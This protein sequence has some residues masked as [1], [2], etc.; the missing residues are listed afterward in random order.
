[1][2]SVYSGIAR[3][4]LDFGHSLSSR[5]LSRCVVR[6]I[7]NSVR[8]NIANC[9]AIFSRL[10]Q[11]SARSSASNFAHGLNLASHIQNRLHHGHARRSAVKTVGLRQSGQRS[12]RD[13]GLCCA[14]AY[15]QQ[16][17]LGKSQ[18]MQSVPKPTRIN[19]TNINRPKNP[20]HD[21]TRATRRVRRGRCN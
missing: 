21:A 19:S 14:A 12:A 20:S 8:V 2:N 18:A 7:Q 17:D 9:A 10:T 13:C 15:A 3:R 1:M 16:R 6:I 11:L 4:R 5:R